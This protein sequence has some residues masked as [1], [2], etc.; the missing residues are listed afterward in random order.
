MKR[1]RGFHYLN[2]EAV[3]DKTTW[4]LVKQKPRRLLQG[5]KRPAF[6][7]SNDATFSVHLKFLFACTGA[8]FGCNSSLHELALA[9]SKYFHKR[10]WSE[11]DRGHL[12]VV[13]YTK[14]AKLL[15]TV[16][17]RHRAHLTP[18][19]VLIDI[20]PPVDQKTTNLSRNTKVQTVFQ[21]RNREKAARIRGHKL[22]QPR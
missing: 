19:T 13:C 10:G 4:L 12:C 22:C 9:R 11:G 7:E 20:F 16:V 21:F 3:R 8:A 17:K 5:Q 15:P 6:S 2:T 18:G 1:K 14:H